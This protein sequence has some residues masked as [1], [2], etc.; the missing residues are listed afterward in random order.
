MSWKFGVMKEWA[1]KYPF[2]DEWLYTIHEF[3]TDA[4]GNHTSCT[5]NAVVA[6]GETL[7]E[8]RESLQRMLDSCDKQVYEEVDG[9][10]R[11]VFE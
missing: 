11:E 7:D 3:Y 8:L 9:K 4:D 2:A 5:K 6:Q 10:L 1:E